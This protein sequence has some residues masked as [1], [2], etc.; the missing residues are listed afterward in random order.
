[1]KGIKEEEETLH[2]LFNGIDRERE[3]MENSK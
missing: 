2:F 1:M 3:K